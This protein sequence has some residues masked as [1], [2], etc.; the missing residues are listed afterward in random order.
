M[1][2]FLKNHLTL[3]D[4]T[5]EVLEKAILTGSIKSGER[6]VETELARKLGISKAP[7]REALKKLEGGGVVQLLPRRGYI[8]KPITLEWR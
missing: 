7:V 6:I 8:V 3:T 2:A 1:E 4:R 5:L